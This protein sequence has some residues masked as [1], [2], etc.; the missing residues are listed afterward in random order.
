LSPSCKSRTLAY[1]VLNAVDAYLSV[2]PATE[3]QAK[4]WRETRVIPCA[5]RFR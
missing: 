5:R 1:G 2:M 3:W 4:K